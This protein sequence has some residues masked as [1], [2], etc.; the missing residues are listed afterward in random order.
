MHIVKQYQYPM[1]CRIPASHPWLHH[2]LCLFM[3]STLA[4]QDNDFNF[5][6]VLDIVLR[7]NT[8]TYIQVEAKLSYV[9]RLVECLYFNFTASCMNILKLE[10]KLKASSKIP[11]E[12]SGPG[13]IQGANFF[14]CL[15]LDI[16]QIISTLLIKLGL[17]GGPRLRFWVHS[18]FVKSLEQNLTQIWFFQ[19]FVSH[20][21]ISQACFNHIFHLP[22][23]VIPFPYRVTNRTL[24]QVGR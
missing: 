6:V 13:A 9:T 1:P 4:M 21:I 22:I 17:Q 24:F 11:K 15:L 14:R 7:S 23:F 10:T 3:Q 2:T 16:I 18:P 8:H 5:R 20:T 12:A 19:D